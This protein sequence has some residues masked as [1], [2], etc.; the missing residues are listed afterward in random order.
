M[1]INLKFDII[2]TISLLVYLLPLFLIFSIFL[3]DLSVVII[4]VL[5]LTYCYKEKKIFLPNQKF[6]LI[7]LFF[8]FFIILSSFF[9]EDYFRSFKTSILFIRFFF[10]FLA[11]ALCV[12]KN[13]KFFYSTGANMVGYP[14]FT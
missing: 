13:D 7:F 5:F 9:S 2:K 11:V 3:A 4:S 12:L 8:Y 6:L 1:K 10:L 14:I